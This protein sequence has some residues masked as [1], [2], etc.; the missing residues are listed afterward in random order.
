MLAM[1]GLGIGEIIGGFLIGQIVDKF[2]TKTAIVCN[3]ITIIVMSA[4]TL[5]FIHQFEF[6]ALPWIMCFLWGFQD[7]GVNTQL[8]ET[9]GFEFDNNANEAFSLYYIY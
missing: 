3:F 6:N 8:Q 2:G 5:V 1:T 7:S 4:V 9:L